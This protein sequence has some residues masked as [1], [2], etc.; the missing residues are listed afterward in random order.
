MNAMAGS[1]VMPLTAD[2]NDNIRTTAPGTEAE[3][4]LAHCKVACTCCW[5]VKVCPLHGDVPHIRVRLRGAGA[6]P[7]RLYVM[8]V[9]M[10][11]VAV[12]LAASAGEKAT[13]K[14]SAHPG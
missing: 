9:A 10:L 8:P 1:V 11:S 7:T 12:A 3:A 6:L 13:W 14:V 4:E 2:L 5:L